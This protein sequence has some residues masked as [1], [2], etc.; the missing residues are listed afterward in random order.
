MRYLFLAQLAAGALAGL[1]FQVGLDNRVAGL[2]AGTG[3]ILAGAFGCFV[4]LKAVPKT[5]AAWLVI[6]F[7][8][9]HLIGVALPMLAFRLLH[10]GEPFSKVAVW[11]LAGPEFHVLATRIFGVWMVSVALAIG[12]ER[13]RSI[14]RARA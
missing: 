1:I 3:F 14:M 12:Y 5:W 6:A 13:Y 9:I 2:I 8:V 11:G 4:G 10:W 7:S